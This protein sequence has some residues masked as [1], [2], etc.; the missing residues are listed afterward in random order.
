MNPSENLDEQIKDLL[1][2]NSGD[3]DVVDYPDIIK[4]AEQQGLSQAELAR[5]IRK[6]YDSIDWRPYNRVDKLLEEIILRGSISEKEAEAIVNAEHE[7]QRPKVVNFILAT[8]RKRGFL[9]REKNSFEYDSFKNRWMTDDAWAKYQTEKVTVEWLEKEAHSLAQI[10]EISFEKP[11]DAK[12]FLRN[13]N[14]LVPVVTTLTKSPSRADEFSKIIESEPNL[15]KRYLSIL[16]HLNPDL[17]FRLL[18][19]DFAGIH[20]LF[21]ATAADYNLFEAAADS[22]VN[23]HLQIWLKETDPVNTGKLTIGSDYNS[24]LNFVY[25]V[26]GSHPFYLTSIRYD[27]PEALM[28]K[29]ESDA[30]LWFTIAAATANRQLPVWLAG[31]GRHDWLSLYEKQIEKINAFAFYSADDKKLAAV[32]SLIQIADAKAATPKIVCHPEKIQLSIEGSKQVQYGIYLKLENRGFA[33]AS[34]FFDNIVNGI[35]LSSNTFTFWSQNNISEHTLTVT[36]EALQL[37]KNKLYTFHILLNTEFQQ[38]KIP[39]EVKVV[40][41]KKAYLLQLLKYAVLGCIFLAGV[42]YFT[43]VMAENDSW[44]ILPAA[45]DSFNFLPK[46]YFAY[47]A[48]LA[49]LL[50]GLIIAI[51]LIRKFEKI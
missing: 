39:V 51:F 22:Y 10:G 46:H 5:R 26:N 24:F 4:D 13:T 17:P 1:L 23:G 2:A 30:S 3:F 50:G 33:R 21:D 8:I 15:D 9:P 41:P 28:Q 37:V 6:V 14:Y 25:R 48:G 16:Y 43:G 44:F 19:R 29:A 35:S 45:S 27:T 7:L 18:N 49:A 40:F 47:F 36:I 38:T 34:V 12:Y 31:A 20:A 32:Q 11:D 42:R